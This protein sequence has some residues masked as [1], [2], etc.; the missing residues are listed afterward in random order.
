MKIRRIIP[1]I[2]L[3]VFLLGSAA[4]IQDGPPKEDTPAPSPLNGRFVY[5]D[6]SMV[7][8]GDD[9]SIDIDISTELAGVTGLPQGKSSGT[10]VF[11]YQN[12]KYRYDKAEYFRIMTGGKTYQFRNSVSLTD[13]SIIAFYND[14]VSNTAVIFRKAAD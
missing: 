13:Q 4:C 14:S 9:I 10:Y 11:I 1:I 5:M 6:S 12:G 8:N 3:A 2:M 7:F